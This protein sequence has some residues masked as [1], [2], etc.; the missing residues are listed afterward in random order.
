MDFSFSWCG[1]W[2]CRTNVVCYFLYYNQYVNDYNLFPFNRRRRFAGDVV[3]DAVDAAHFVD[4]AIG[5]FA[6]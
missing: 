1:F 5:D 4:D 6:Q 3:D 2:L